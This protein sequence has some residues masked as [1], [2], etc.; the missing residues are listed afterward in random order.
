MGARLYVPGLGRFLQT[1]PVEG[2][3][4]NNYDY[5]SADPINCT[6]LNGQY[7][8]SYTYGLGSDGWS[9]SVAMRLLAM[10]FGGIFP[11]SS[12]CSSLYVGE[13]CALATGPYHNPVRVTSVGATSFSFL[14]LGGHLEGANKTISFSFFNRGRGLFLNV[15]A[16]GRNNWWQK[17]PLAR[18][19]NRL[20]ANH[21]WGDLAGN[22][23]GAL[24]SFGGFLRGRCG[25]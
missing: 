14:S 24:G 8:Y 10:D 17:I 22:M 1:D 5:C 19:V 13:R 15:R 25:C 11:F 23:R 9:A 12:S 18:R 7:G 21:V 2:G 4:A 3:S 20:F 6:D 16:G